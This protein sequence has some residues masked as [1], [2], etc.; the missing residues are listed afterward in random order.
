VAGH[1]VV[2][3]Y[4]LVPWVFVMAAG[5]CFGQVFLLQP[6]VRRRIILKLGV[7][8]TIG[9]LVLRFANVYGDPAPWSH[10]KS[11]LFTLLS[12]LNCTKY[13][14]SLEFLLMTLGPALL[15]LAYLDPRQFSANHP[16]V[17]LGRVP[18][19]FFFAHFYAIHLVAVLMAWIRYGRV[20][21]MFNPVPSMGGPRELFPPGFGYDLWVV[22]AV[23]I[24]IVVSLYPLCR[25]FANLKA[26]R[27]DWWLGYL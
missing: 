25:W 10:Q 19:F 5:F 17:V 16:F 22:Y 15:V 4:P 6:A 20:E 21:F 26:R 23:W 12:F 2:V 3:S 7:V 8:L 18:L 13:P 11:G 14:P 9:F 1:I 24:F 27:N